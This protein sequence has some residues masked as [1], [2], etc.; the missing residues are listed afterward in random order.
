VRE[1]AAEILFRSL[2]N[3]DN[4]IGSMQSIEHT[5]RARDSAAEDH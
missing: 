2:L 1:Q 5:L 3:A 4:P